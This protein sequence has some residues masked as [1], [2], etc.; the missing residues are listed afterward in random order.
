MADRF[1]VRE[2]RRGVSSRLKPLVDGAFSI[3]GGGQMMSQEFGLALDEID[4]LLV[5]HHRDA[6]V[7][8]LTFRPKQ[9]A[10]SGVLNQRVLKQVVS[11]RSSA[12]AEQKPCLGE[13]IEPRLQLAGWPLGDGL[14]QVVAELAAEDCADL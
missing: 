5:Q 10:V 8:F 1:Q 4:K 9:S 12:S 14:D 2:T 7:Q 11:V 6:R 3:A 13:P